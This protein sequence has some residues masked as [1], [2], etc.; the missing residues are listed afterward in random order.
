MDERVAS[1][2]PEHQYVPTRIVLMGVSGSG[3]SSIGKILAPLIDGTYSDGDGFHPQQNIDKMVGGTPLTDEDR[4]PWLKQVGEALASAEKRLV[5]GCSALK[6]LYRDSIREVAGNAV[7]FVHLS[8]SRQLL[9][10]R[11][12]LRKGHFMPESLLDSQFADL[13]PPEKEEVS[14]TVDVE[15]SVEE[16]AHSIAERVHSMN[17]KDF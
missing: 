17:I 11:M 16:I 5:I 1:G 4:W 2:G 7:V 8:G 12:S 13:Q 9:A 3:K 15:P 10:S 14:I 6:R